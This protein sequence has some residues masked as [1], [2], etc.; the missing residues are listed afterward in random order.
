MYCVFEGGCTRTDILWKY[1]IYIIHIY[2]MHICGNV[3]IP[4]YCHIFYII[5]NLIWNLFLF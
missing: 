2:Y 3:L 5:N 1:N 4:F